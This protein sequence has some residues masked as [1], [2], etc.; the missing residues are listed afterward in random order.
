M[1]EVKNNTMILRRKRPIMLIIQ[2]KRGTIN[3]HPLTILLKISVK[4]TVV[5]LLYHF[6]TGIQ[7]HFHAAV[8]LASSLGFVGSYGL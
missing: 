6:R 2:T 5:C 3:K 8:Q 1:V 7:K 4:F